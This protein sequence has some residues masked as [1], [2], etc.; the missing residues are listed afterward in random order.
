MSRVIG[1][2]LIAA[3]PRPGRLHGVHGLAVARLSRHNDA[4]R[5]LLLPARSASSRTPASSRLGLQSRNQ[6][7][8]WV[9]HILRPICRTAGLPARIAATDLLMAGVSAFGKQSVAPTCGRTFIGMQSRSAE[10]AIGASMLRRRTRRDENEPQSNTTGSP[11]P[12]TQ[13]QCIS[14]MRNGL[15]CWIS[16]S[17]PA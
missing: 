7:M 14:G 4:T 3:R 10:W 1:F 13:K 8:G 16:R 6:P 12:T 17:R 5:R 11:N 15:T 2:I 9:S